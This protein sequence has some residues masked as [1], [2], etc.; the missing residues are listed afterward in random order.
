MKIYPTKQDIEK[1][2]EQVLGG[3]RQYILGYDKKAEWLNNAIRCLFV[4]LVL[5]ANNL[6]NLDVKNAHYETLVKKLSKCKTGFPK[7]K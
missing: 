3:I 4:D 5:E 1:H 2:T 6:G 7:R